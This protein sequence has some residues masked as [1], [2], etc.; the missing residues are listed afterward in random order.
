MERPRDSRM[1][2][3]TRKKKKAVKAVEKA[4][5]RAVKKGVT[6]DIVEAA[7]ERAIIKVDRDKTS[8]PT[9]KSKSVKAVKKRRSTRV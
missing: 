9:T 2:R 8:Q 7:V 3:K 4:V 1:N 5:K 6:G